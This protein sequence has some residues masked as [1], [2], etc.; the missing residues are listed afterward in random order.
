MSALKWNA[1]DLNQNQ[2]GMRPTYKLH[3]LDTQ[4]HYKF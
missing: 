3:H 4:D 1:Y 2:M